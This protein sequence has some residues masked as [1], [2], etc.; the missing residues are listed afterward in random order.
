MSTVVVERQIQ[1]F[2]VQISRYPFDDAGQSGDNGL[3]G[4][5]KMKITRFILCLLQSSGRIV[6]TDNDRVPLQ[7]P[8]RE[9]WMH[10]VTEMNWYL[11]NGLW[12]IFPVLVTANVN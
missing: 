11:P 4:N 5:R 6:R 10:R 1:D 8:L 12:E 7:V 2:D 3:A 9:F